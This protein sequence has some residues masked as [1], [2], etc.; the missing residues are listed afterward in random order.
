MKIKMSKYYSTYNENE[1][2]LQVISGTRRD[3]LYFPSSALSGLGRV[4]S[5]LLWFIT[6]EVVGNFIFITQ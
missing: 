5:P 2:V 1:I 4:Y 3:S 6:I